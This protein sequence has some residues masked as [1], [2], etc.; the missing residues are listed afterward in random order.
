MSPTMELFK[1]HITSKANTVLSSVLELI[2]NEGLIIA[3]T[4]KMKPV[5]NFDEVIPTATSEQYHEDVYA[6]P[7]PAVNKL[8]LIVPPGFSI[9]QI[10]V[11]DINGHSM[12]ITFDERDR[13]F[14]TQN[15]VPGFYIVKLSTSNGNVK[16]I[17][18][19]K[20]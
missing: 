6:F 10:E 16:S 5:L 15:F 1:L 20:N 8:S 19:V 4:N 7:N 12:D 3:E 14:A 13:S 9:Q 2:P 11:C 18:F 17:P